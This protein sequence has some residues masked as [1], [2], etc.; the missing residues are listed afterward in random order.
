MEFPRSVLIPLD[1][2]PGANFGKPLPGKAALRFDVGTVEFST[3]RGIGFSEELTG[4]FTWAQIGE[5]GFT[6]DLDRA[7]LDISRTENIPEATEDGRSDEFVGVYIEDASVGLPPEVV[8]AG[9]T[10]RPRRSSDR[11]S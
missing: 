5:T 10:G 11:S 6:V 8:Q 7:K 3:G 9:R 2:T 1:E 4:D